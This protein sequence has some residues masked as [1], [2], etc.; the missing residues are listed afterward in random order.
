MKAIVFEKPDNSGVAVMYFSSEI[1]DS[2]SFFKAQLPDVKTYFEIN[3]SELPIEN[4]MAWY[5][6]DGQIKIDQ[7]KLKQFEREQMPDLSP[8]QFEWK[9]E[10]VG[11][12][13]T[14]KNYVETT[15]NTLI[16]IAYNRVIYFKRTDPI[17]IQ[18]MTDL[19]LTAEQVDHIWLNV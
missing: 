1:T 15:E 7:E 11:L 14:I 16:K 8:I 12:L 2:L 4:K 13:T 18:A 9:L 10:K 5:I 3:E 19:G 6:E 17:L